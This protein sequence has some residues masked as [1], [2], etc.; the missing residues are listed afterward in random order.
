MSGDYEYLPLPY[1]VVVHRTDKPRL[2]FGF[3]KD[4]GVNWQ[5]AAPERRTRDEA[6]VEWARLI[7]AD[8]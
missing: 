2:P 4:S 6:T 7:R 1:E 5:P 3:G 8:R